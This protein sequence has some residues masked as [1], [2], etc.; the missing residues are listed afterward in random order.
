MIPE[1]AFNNQASTPI[2]DF[3]LVR[4]R[5]SSLMPKPTE[6]TILGNRSEFASSKAELR[7]NDMTLI[8][9]SHTPY[10]L[11]RS[12]F[13]HPEIWIPF[14]GNMT[15]SDGESE[16]KYGGSRAYFSTAEIRNIRTTTT[17]ALGVRFN[18]QRL[19]A[20]HATMVGA[21]NIREIPDHSRTLEMNGNGVNFS[22]LIKN[23]L[24]QI[25]ELQMDSTA[26]E[27]LG[28]DD[29]FYRLAVALLNPALLRDP[30]S[31]GRQRIHSQQ[32]IAKLCDYL[33]ENLKQPISLTD[34]ENISGLSARV[35]QYSFQKA[36]GMRP[37]Q[38]LQKQ[39]LH[40]ARFMLLKCEAPIKVTSLAY[41]FCFPSPSVF[42]RAYQAEFGELPSETL[43]RK[44]AYY[45]F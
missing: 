13:A 7:L 19:N 40:A 38:W 11:D 45:Y 42:A 2:R 12:G 41:E 27:K 4:D 31:S 33:S 20:V 8:A 21:S 18:M 39:R 30:E 1:L 28:I 6:F 23:L 16:F 36:F 15:A 14:A 26:L 37:K 5:L 29:S 3:R 22:T 17:S 44:K 43:A 24:R 10:Q 9:L 35:L 25:D 32:G 34:M